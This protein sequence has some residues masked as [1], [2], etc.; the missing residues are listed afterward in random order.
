VKLTEAQ[1]CYLRL[2]EAMGSIDGYPRSNPSRKCIRTLID[3]G[4]LG[5][6]MDSGRQYTL[7]PAGRAAL[8]QSKEK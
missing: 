7:T 3:R 4:L 2:A 1:R 5:A 8:E 6:R